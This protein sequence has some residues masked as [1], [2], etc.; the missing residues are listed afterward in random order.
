M[1][2]AVIKKEKDFLLDM[3]LFAK[4]N[5]GFMI[6]LI[7]FLCSVLFLQLNVSQSSQVETKTNYAL[8]MYTNN[9]NQINSYLAAI[10][11]QLLGKKE[12]VLDEYFLV[13]AK[14]D[15]EWMNDAQVQL[16]NSKPNT[17][18]YAKEAAFSTFLLKMIELNDAS[19]V[20]V[21]TPDYNSVISM[22]ENEQITIPLILT[23][24][25]IIDLFEGDVREANIFSNTLNYLFSSYID[26]K[27]NSLAN[28]TV[29]EKKYIDSKKLLLVP[30]LS[31][32]LE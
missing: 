21:G 29:L 10:D 31:E 7:I 12:D 30:E 1:K 19:S 15:F 3:L 23:Q 24:E 16:F 13:S 28:S 5:K 9:Q 17:D 27:K 8:D 25:K 4:E 18:L 6:A 20:R 2:K 26:F 32:Y 14:E 22:A 11:E